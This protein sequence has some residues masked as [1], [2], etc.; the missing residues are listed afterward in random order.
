[1]TTSRR[2]AARSTIARSIIARSIIAQ[3][4]ASV[5]V[6]GVWALPAAAQQT[7]TERAQELYFNGAQLYEEGDYRAAITAWEASWA[8]SEAPLLQ[9]NIA[10]AHERLGNF[11]EAITHLNQYRALA[12]S[13]EHDE[14]TSRIRALEIRRDE[15]LAREAAEQERLAAEARR[16]EEERRRLEEEQRRL[17][18]ERRREEERRNSL[19]M[20]PTGPEGGADSGGGGLSG[21]QIGMITTAIVGV[22]AGTA[23]GLIENSAADE[24]EAAC[25]A[26]IC[27]ET[28]ESDVKRARSSALISNIGFGVAGAAAAVFIVTLFTGRKDEESDTSLSFAPVPVRGGAA[29][30]AGARF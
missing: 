20:Q 29:V 22:G 6:L 14:L 16:L 18:E 15:Q 23:F 30:Q 10:N 3:C 17:D 9:Y 28:A 19:V 8:I 1:M 11:D 13:E 4:I 26:S 25:I 21:L 12:P 2:T 7:D 5:F 27:P 24:V